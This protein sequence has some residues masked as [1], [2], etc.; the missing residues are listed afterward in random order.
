MARQASIPLR[1]AGKMSEPHERE[2]FDT[3]VAPLLGEDIEYIGEVGGQDKLELVGNALCLL[4]PILWPEPFG[5][6]MIE[7]LAAGTPVITTGL[8]AAPEI[9]THGVNGYVASDG[10]TLLRALSAAPDIDRN[11]CR[12]TASE[13]FSAQRLV[14][15]HVAVYRTVVELSVQTIGRG[16]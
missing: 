3:S 8:G 10:R 16:A 11:V 15:D 5:L 14:A 1:I 2:Y 12:R 13:R 6:V 7:A 9:I 4:N